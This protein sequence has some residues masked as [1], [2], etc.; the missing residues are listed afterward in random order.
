MT[1]Q[2]SK[3]V[4]FMTIFERNPKE[5][6]GYAE[7]LMAMEKHTI[8]PPP[9]K[10]LTTKKL[11]EL[12]LDDLAKLSRTYDLDPDKLIQHPFNGGLMYLHGNMVPGESHLCKAF[13]IGAGGMRYDAITYE[14]QR[15]TVL[16]VCR[17][18]IRDRLRCR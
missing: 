4:G 1:L 14:E 15:S 16:A 3:D 9:T 11:I 18:V 6:T 13:N 12:A 2:V 7:R 5:G 10:V 17:R 8:A